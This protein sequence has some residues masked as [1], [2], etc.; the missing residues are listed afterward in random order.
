MTGSV[1]TMP[2][3]TS[4]VGGWLNYQYAPATAAMSAIGIS[5]FIVSNNYLK[6]LF[7]I[8]QPR[9]ASRGAALNA[10]DTLR[11]SRPRRTPP[12]HTAGRHTG[13]NVRAS[14]TARRARQ[15]SPSSCLRE[16]ACVR[17]TRAA[18]RSADRRWDRHPSAAAPLSIPVGSSAVRKSGFG[19][20]FTA[21][22]ALPARIESAF[23]RLTTAA[24][25]PHMPEEYEADEYRVHRTAGS[26]AARRSEE[27]AAEAEARIPDPDPASRV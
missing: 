20:T 17:R 19:H 27:E 23:H 8:C 14:R 21:G 13:R 7:E 24:A 5:R 15:R 11:R 26:A 6:Q 1:V 4:E 25:R 12:G 22:P 18:G 10:V 9:H 3:R 16:S 2:V